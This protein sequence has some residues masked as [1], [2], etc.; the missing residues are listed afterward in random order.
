MLTSSLLLL[1]ST[2]TSVLAFN[3]LTTR[4]DS[5]TSNCSVYGIDFVDGGSYFINSN[6][7][8]NFSVVQQ[9]SGCNDDSASV[10]L[11]QQSTED[12][13]ECTSVPTGQY[14]SRAT[15]QNST[16]LIQLSVPSDTSQL[17]TCPLEDDQMSSGEWTILVIGN[18]GDGNPFAY[19]R[20]FSL[21]VGPQET[22]TATQTVTYTQ[23]LTPVVNT[24]S[25]ITSSNTFAIT[26]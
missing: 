25:K 21:T 9:F 12:E 15:A 10:L 7:T 14:F 1:A 26:C 20:D 19:E 6:S 24:T 5:P 11:V 8:A 2:A 22:T 23:T 4:Q 3:L 18:N 16:V 17:S 13:W